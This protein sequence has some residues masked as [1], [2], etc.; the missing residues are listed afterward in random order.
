MQIVW[1]R[2]EA[3]VDNIRAAQPPS[4]RAVVYRAR[5]DESELVARS[6]RERLEGAS[7]DARRLALLNLIEG[8]EQ[9]D[10]DELARY[11]NSPCGRTPGLAP[12]S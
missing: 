3:T 2:G 7:E 5:Y 8:L 4:Q 12:L 6:L 11:A 1:G 10:L 9:D